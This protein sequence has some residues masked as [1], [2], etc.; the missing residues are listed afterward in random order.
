MRW[1]LPYCRA[2]LERVRESLSGNSA[3]FPGISLEEH[4]LRLKHRIRLPTLSVTD[5][6]LHMAV[7]LRSGLQ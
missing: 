2:L 3:H 7:G 1:S 5:R 4:R 6:S